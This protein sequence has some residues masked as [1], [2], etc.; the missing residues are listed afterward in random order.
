[1]FR[2]RLFAPALLLAMGSVLVASARNQEVVQLDRPLRE[3]QFRLAGFEVEER[4]I[5]ENEQQVAGMS[6]Y[7]FRIFGQQ[8]DS[9][10]AFSVYVGYYESQTTGRTIHS[11][12]NCLPRA[13]WQ[14]RCNSLADSKQSGWKKTSS[15]YTQTPRPKTERFL[16]LEW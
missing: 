12:R 1:M 4:A 5:S 2:L 10:Q 3:V 14:T 8:G 16:V 9:A 7:V 6:D 15:V 11:P 13:G